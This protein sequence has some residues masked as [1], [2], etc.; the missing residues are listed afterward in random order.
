[1]CMPSKYRRYRKPKAVYRTMQAILLIILLVGVV[2][3][4]VEFIFAAK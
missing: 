1:M 3:F 2:G 4:A